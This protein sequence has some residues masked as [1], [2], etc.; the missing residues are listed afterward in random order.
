MSYKIII[1]INNIPA[2]N[3]AITSVVNNKFTI[4]WMEGIQKS[5]AKIHFFRTQNAK[6]FLV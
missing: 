1:V 2:G 3:L 4:L 6:M 5:G